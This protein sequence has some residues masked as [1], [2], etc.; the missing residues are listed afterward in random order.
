M[1]ARP[2]IEAIESFKETANLEWYHTVI[3]R[4]QGL[5]SYPFDIGML[6]NPIDQPTKYVSWSDNIK[7]SKSESKILF[8]FPNSKRINNSIVEQIKDGISVDLCETLNDFISD[9][10]R[11]GI[12]LHWKQSI[13]DRYFNH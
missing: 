13:V 12:E 9:C 1:I 3:C 6:I 4:L 10:N 7:W 2:F 11:R 5:Y 8:E